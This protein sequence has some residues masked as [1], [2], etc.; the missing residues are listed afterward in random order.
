[1]VQG[2]TGPDEN[3]TGGGVGSTLFPRFDARGSAVS[4]LPS[5]CFEISKQNRRVSVLSA[6]SY[7]LSAGACTAIGMTATPSVRP[8][9]AQVELVENAVW[10]RADS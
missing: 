10:L 7:Q 2:C 1:M 3:R 4:H 6:L 8:F 9:L 5:N